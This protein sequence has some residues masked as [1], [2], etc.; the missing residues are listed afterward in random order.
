MPNITGIHSIANSGDGTASIYVNLDDPNAN[1][2]TP[3][4][5]ICH[6]DERAIV[7]MD[8][9]A[10]WEALTEYHGP[11]FTEVCI[12]TTFSVDA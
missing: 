8:H 6:V 12:G 9:G 5:I 3:G 7:G 10:I 1:E 4:V 2:V 11:I